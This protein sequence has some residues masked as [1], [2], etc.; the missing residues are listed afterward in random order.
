MDVLVTGAYGQC[1][2]A[3]Y[4]HLDHDWTPL[5]RSDR[6][7]DHPYGGFETYVADVAGYDAIRP[8]FDGQDAVVHMAAK[9][10]EGPWGV[11]LESN[12]VGTYNVLEAA[13][14][15]EVQTVVFGSTNHVVGRYEDEHAPDIY[16]PGHGVVVD[17]DSPIRPDSRYGTSKAFGEALG[18]YYVENFEYPKQFYALRIGNVSF[19]EYDHPYAWPEQRIADGE[20]ERGS[21]EHAEHVGRMKGMW[22]SRPDFAHEVECCLRDGGVEFGVFGAVSDNGR[23]WLSIEGARARIGYDPQDDGEEWDGPPDGW[24]PPEGE[25]PTRRGG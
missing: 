2:T 8:A 5:N 24:S 22:H 9:S 19:P 21:R 4:D 16:F 7:P 1:G 23:R 6:P 10:G 11:I 17:A 25:A 18:R 15:A 13:R 14:Q 20:Y 12:I 3:L